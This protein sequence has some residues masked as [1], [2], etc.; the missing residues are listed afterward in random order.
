MLPLQVIVCKTK[1]AVQEDEQGARVSLVVGG[2]YDLHFTVQKKIAMFTPSSC[3]GE[4]FSLPVDSNNARYALVYNPEGDASR[5]I[6]GYTF[7]GVADLAKAQPTPAVVCTTQPVVSGFFNMV[8]EGE[9]LAL[10]KVYATEEGRVCIDAYSFKTESIKTLD[11]DGCNCGFTTQPREVQLPLQRIV[12]E[13][14]P[15]LPYQVHVFEVEGAREYSDNPNS[16]LRLLSLH[17]VEQTMLV[18]TSPQTAHEVLEISVTPD[19]EVKMIEVGGRE[20]LEMKS[21][22]WLLQ[23][24]Y[25]LTRKGRSVSVSG[26]GLD[27]GKTSVSSYPGPDIFR[28]HL[29]PG[30]Y[31]LYDLPYDVHAQTAAGGQPRAESLPASKGIPSGS[32]LKKNLTLALLPS[33]SMTSNG[34]GTVK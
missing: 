20:L 25:H 18:A 8:E 1:P 29:Q 32:S 10:R 24:K 9:I 12:K 3:S 6:V 34:A 14:N 30:G 21:R 27:S 19:T 22:T 7:R 26:R 28:P 16:S 11:D 13:L 33:P 5:A 4:T 31:S 15:T 17:V 2:L 23:S